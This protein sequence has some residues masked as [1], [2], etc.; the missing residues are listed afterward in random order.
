MRPPHY[1]SSPNLLPSRYIPPFSS[2]AYVQLYFSSAINLNHHRRPK[3]SIGDAADSSANHKN[4]AAHSSAHQNR[5][6]RSQSQLYVIL[7]LLLI[8]SQDPSFGP[9]SFRRVVVTAVPWYRERHLRR[10]SLGSVLL[11]TLLR[12]VTFNLN[13]LRDVF[14]LSN[15][16]AVL[17]NLSP[18]VSGLHGYAAMRLASVTVSCMK[19]CTV[20]TRK[21]GGRH[22]DEGDITGVLGMYREVSVASLKNILHWK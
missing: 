20:L 5:S 16:C 21:R 3:K 18:H 19:K 22:A 2:A 17:L 7:I 12:S 8:F 4:L 1:I 9:D 10:I 13:R 15:C 11:L 6:F 14:L